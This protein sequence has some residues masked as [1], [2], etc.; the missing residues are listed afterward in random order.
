MSLGK[1]AVN[2]LIR[3]SSLMINTPNIVPNS[4]RNAIDK[5]INKKGREFYFRFEN[6][7]NVDLSIKEIGMEYLPAHKAGEV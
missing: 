7:D 1:N 3:A 5:P 4:V 6:A 2:A